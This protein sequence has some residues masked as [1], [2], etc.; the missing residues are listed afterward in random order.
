MKKSLVI[1]PAVFLAV[2][3]A[4]A[5][6]FANAAN[7]DKPGINMEYKSMFS[8]NTSLTDEQPNS[9]S[10]SSQSD[11]N[12]SV[13]DGSGYRQDCG[14]FIDD[15][16]DGICDNCADVSCPQNGNGSGHCQVCGNYVD[17]NNDGICD[18]CAGVS[19]PQ[20]GN[21]SGHCQVCGNYVDGNNDGICD[22]YAGGSCIGNGKGKG[23]HRGNGCGRRRN[24]I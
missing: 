20:N 12:N 10:V 8:R 22:N 6:I 2:G 4:T 18:N 14:N 15:N 5:G 21:G 24:G 19:C 9:S 7:M 13:F 3:A 17:G 23:H 16:N 1:V 11:V